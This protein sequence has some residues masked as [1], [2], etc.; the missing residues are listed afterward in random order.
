MWL[1]VVPYLTHEAVWATLTAIAAVPGA[2]VA[3]D[4]GRPPEAYPA[5][6]RA[7]YEAVIALAAAAGEP[8]LSFFM[9]A[10]LAAEIAAL[11]FGEIEDVSPR[12]I[13][14]R[15]FG[16]ADAPADLPGAHLLRAR[17]L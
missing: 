9:P 2:E 17:R 8:W 5:E 4:Y 14:M 11:G 6:R 13:A 10:E 1:G 3:F 16:E 12:Q 7:D 15:Y